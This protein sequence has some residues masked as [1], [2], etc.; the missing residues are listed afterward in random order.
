MTTLAPAPA[1]QETSTDDGDELGH[2]WCCIPDT[3]VCGADLTDV[4]EGE[5][6]PQVNCVVC[7]DLV[8]LPCPRC[9][10]SEGST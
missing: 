7:L 10:R 6:D 2:Y 4:E 9:G 5:G 1:P 3:A 8:K